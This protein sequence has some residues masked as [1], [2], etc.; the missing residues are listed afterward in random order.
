MAIAATVPQPA[1]AAPREPTGKWMVDFGETQCIAQRSYG[2]PDKPLT[3]MPKAPE[4][5]GVLQL[6]VIRKGAV[7]SFAEQLDGRLR[8]G[9][10]PAKQLTALAYTPPKQRF[11]VFL[12]NLP[13]A[14]V[15][16]WPTSTSLDVRAEASLREELALTG[17]HPLLKIMDECVAD[18]RSHWNY[19]REGV[20]SNHRQSAMG[21]LTGLIRSEDYPAINI[22]NNQTGRVKVVLLVGADG[23]V[24]DCSLTETS[25]VAALDAQT[26]VLIKDRAKLR[27]AIG[28]DGRPARDVVV[29][30]VHW[31]IR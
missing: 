31:L 11:R 17:L 2:T 1:A 8:A 24:A 12:Y 18:L 29:Q 25:G 13:R 27:P 16:A 21:D 9:N 4:T 19:T 20:P 15:A 3:L 6:F 23:K 14:D 5:G 7:R 22:R 26:C 28:A 10:A 30:A